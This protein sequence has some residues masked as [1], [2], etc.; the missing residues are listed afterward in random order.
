MRQYTLYVHAHCLVGSYDKFWS[1]LLKH[2]LLAVKHKRYLLFG[3]EPRIIGKSVLYIFLYCKNR[4]FL[5]DI[6]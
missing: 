4:A 2:K 1:N 6:V 3:L 5:N